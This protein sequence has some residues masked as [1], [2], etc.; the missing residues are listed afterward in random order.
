MPMTAV[1]SRPLG[2]SFWARAG[3][4]SDQNAQIESNPAR[5]SSP[6]V[7]CFSLA[8]IR[9][10]TRRDSLGAKK[11]RSPSHVS[12]IEAWLFMKITNSSLP[13]LVAKCQGE[14]VPPKYCLFSYHDTATT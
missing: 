2:A 13:P 6:R 11:E 1:L 10:A 12:P 5:A 3:P 7:T 9:M 14:L 4:Q 8:L